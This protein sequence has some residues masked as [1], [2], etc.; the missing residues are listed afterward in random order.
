MKSSEVL[1]QKIEQGLFSIPGWQ[2]AHPIALGS[3][4]RGELSPKSDLDMLF[5]GDEEKISEV[6]RKFQEKGYRLRARTPVDLKDWTKGVQSKDIISI[7]IFKAFT[8]QGRLEAEV[9]KQQ[10]V[11]S[12][13]LC[14]KVF[15]DVLKER[16]A[17]NQRYD[18][19]NNFLEPNVKQGP[20]GLRD[21]DQSLQVMALL[22]PLKEIAKSNHHVHVVLEQSKRFLLQIRE[23]L[24]L[25]GFQDQLVATEQTEMGLRLG[26]K[27]HKDF[28][29]KVSQTFSRAHFYSDWI[30]GYLR[31]SQRQKNQ[32][33]KFK[34]QTPQG[35]MLILKKDSSILAQQWVRSKMDLVHKRPL[36]ER[37]RGRLLR[38]AILY[39]TSDEITKAVFQSQWIRKLCP[40]IKPLI[41]YVQHDQYHR[42]AAEAHLMQAVR[43]VKRVW[44][45]AKNLGRLHWI[46]SELNLRDWEILSWAA[47]Y[48]DLAKGVEGSSHS[49]LGEIWV[50]KDLL[51]FGIKPEILNEVAFLVKN[52][53]QLSI[54]AFRKNPQDPK[55]WTEF[56]ELGFNS[57]RILLLAAFTVIDIRATNPDAWTDWKSNL[58]SDCVKA[59]RNPE[60]KEFYVLT[61][62]LL[63]RFS[64][65]LGEKIDPGLVHYFSKLTIERD[66]LLVKELS[67]DNNERIQIRILRDRK[68]KIWLRFQTQNDEIG[69]VAKFVRSLFMAGV[70]VQQALIQTLPEVG[71]YD[72]F[73]ISNMKSTVQLLRRV[74]AG[75]AVGLVKEPPQVKFK[76]IELISESGD[77]VILSFQGVDQRG[78]LWAVAGKL[79]GLGVSIL[80]ARVHTWG[81]QVEDLIH[82]KPDP[83]LKQ[84]IKSLQ[85]QWVESN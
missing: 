45:S 12:P 74:E 81:R 15:F 1:I 80:S 25:A 18:S 56:F 54:A 42:L 46:H 59:L 4:A 70:S 23:Q 78:L 8:E 57:K 51:A 50:K 58:L 21:I 48:H 5:I 22:D 53:L 29:K 84:I 3:W 35:L 77:E 7:L 27:S 9:Q 67:R 20:G 82:V 40:R 39:R 75:L 62:S 66:L 73:Q 38:K 31:A 13:R 83:N 65:K 72:L 34:A 47:L 10:I 32:V 11:Q 37:A 2:K 85:L 14:R 16:L 17:R 60:K 61:Q 43:E 6:V 44:K 28:M 79:Q 33:S 68:D 36:T 64:K 41:G 19:L 26:F 52:H 71:V 30:F 55:T 63:S 49:D 24:H 69:L 76:K